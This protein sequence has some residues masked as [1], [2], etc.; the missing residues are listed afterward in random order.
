MAAIDILDAHVDVGGAEATPAAG[1][2]CVP[3]ASLAR[4]E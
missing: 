1:A 3:A 4:P 2:S